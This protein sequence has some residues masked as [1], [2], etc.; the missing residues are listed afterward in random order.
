MGCADGLDD[1]FFGTVKNVKDFGQS[2]FWLYMAQCTRC[3]QNWLVAQEER[4]FDEY[5]L[6]RLSQAQSRGILENDIWPERFSSYEGV[7]RLGGSVVS[8]CQFID[9]VAWSLV[10]S[11]EELRK[12]RPD[13]TIAEIADLLGITESRAEKV[14][15]AI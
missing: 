1:R 12:E 6:A 15:A 5:F 2:K 8:H 13:I 10:W 4:I 11:A 14:V 3:E 7:L 9:T